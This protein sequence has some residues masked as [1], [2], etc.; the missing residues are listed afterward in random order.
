MRLHVPKMY[1]VYFIGRLHNTYAGRLI[2][3]KA[4]V[5]A[6]ELRM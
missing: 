5:I 6:C 3:F 2:E 1:N 4:E